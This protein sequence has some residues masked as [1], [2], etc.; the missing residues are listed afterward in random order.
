VVTVAGL[1]WAPI[2]TTA[3]AGCAVLMLTGWRYR[4]IF[5]ARCTTM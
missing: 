3:T 4:I 5:R 2:V 1:G